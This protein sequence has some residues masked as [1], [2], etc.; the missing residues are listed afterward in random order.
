MRNI[1]REQRRSSMVAAIVTILM[2]VLLI[3]VPNRSAQ[4][5]CALLGSCL[6]YTS[7]SPRDCS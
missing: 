5:L 2:G 6:L 7:P 1:L 3:F 4:L